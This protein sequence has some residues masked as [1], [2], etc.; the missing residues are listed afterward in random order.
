MTI[1]FQNSVQCGAQYHFYM[2]TQTSLAVPQDNGGL[3]LYSATQAPDYA[4]RSVAAATG[5]PAGKIRIA[6]TRVGGGYGGK[7]TRSLPCAVAV[8]VA[9]ILTGVPVRM[10]VQRIKFFRAAINFRRRA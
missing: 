1:F 3:Q 2:E 4:V 10:Q 7:A 6:V 9:S 5:L 8:S